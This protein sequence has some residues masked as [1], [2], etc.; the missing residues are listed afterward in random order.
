MAILLSHPDRRRLCH[1]KVCSYF[2]LVLHHMQKPS[3]LA[4]V[5]GKGGREDLQF[6][7]GV[8]QVDGCASKTVPKSFTTCHCLAGALDFFLNKQSCIGSRISKNYFLQPQSAH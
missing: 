1:A 4:Q 5:I 3:Q 6:V 2:C 7:V 8:A